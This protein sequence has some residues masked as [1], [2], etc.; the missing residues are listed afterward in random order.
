MKI[1]VNVPDGKSGDWEV[2][3][4]DISE[5]EA[6]FHNLRCAIKRE[7][8]SMIEP[9]TYKRLTNGGEVVMTNT[10]M[11]VRTHRAFIRAAHGRVLLNGLGLGMVLSAILAKPE[12]ESV[13]VIEI[14]P[15][16]IRLTGPTFASDP[17]VRII[18]A[19]AFEWKPEPGEKFDCV[20]HD[21]WNDICRGNLPGMKKL[22]R[23]YAK[24][25]KFQGCWSRELLRDL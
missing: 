4:I 9:G 15:D 12:V 25:A 23:K 11:E 17:R 24:R 6:R 8:V 18:E 19:D 20:W 13:T 21:V 16:V 7:S 22:V 2:S 10:P 14:S 5:N 1:D 3:T